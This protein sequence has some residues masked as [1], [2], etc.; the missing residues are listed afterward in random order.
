M[1]KITVASRNFANAPKK[2][3]LAI[4]GLQNSRGRNVKLQ[5]NDHSMWLGQAGTTSTL[6][7]TKV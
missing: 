2:G 1:T 5:M 3:F 4:H 7:K 6:N